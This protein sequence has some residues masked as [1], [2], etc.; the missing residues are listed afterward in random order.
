[1]PSQVWNSPLSLVDSPQDKQL[2]M[3]S[4]P[5][6]PQSPTVLQGGTGLSKPLTKYDL[7][8]I[9]PVSS[10]LGAGKNGCCE[11]TCVGFVI[12]TR[13]RHFLALLPAF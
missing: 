10:W 5:I 8:S 9:G 12:M 13:R 2:K 7:L 11:I 1:M 6:I 3:G 4:S